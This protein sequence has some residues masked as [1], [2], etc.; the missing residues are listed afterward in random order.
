MIFEKIA[1]LVFDLDGTLLHHHGLLEK[2]EVLVAP[3]GIDIDTLRSAVKEVTTMG[4]SPERLC[5]YLK[6]PHLLPEVGKILGDFSQ[7]YYADGLE[8]LAKARSQGLT[9]H[10]VTRGEENFQKLKIQP[11]ENLFNGETFIVPAQ[12]RINKAIHLWPLAQQGQVLY[13]DDKIEELQDIQ[14]FFV[15]NDPEAGRNMLLVWLHRK[16]DVPMPQAKFMT[17]KNLDELWE[18]LAKM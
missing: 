13:I 17:V 11:I 1:Y 14:E 8:V 5:D 3:E 7:N 9:T 16:E 12:P 18:K 15:V 6:I 4:F 2:V 10:I